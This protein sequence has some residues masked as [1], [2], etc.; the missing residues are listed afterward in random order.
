MINSWDIMT[1]ICLIMP[2]CKAKNGI[3]KNKE[4]FVIE[5]FSW[6]EPQNNHLVQLSDHF[7]A[8]PKLKHIIKSKCILNIDRPGAL[9]ELFHDTQTKVVITREILLIEEAIILTKQLYQSLAVTFCKIE[10]PLM[11]IA[12]ILLQLI[13]V[14][15]H[16]QTTDI[17]HQL[18][19]NYPCY[20]KV[21]IP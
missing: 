4:T 13:C 15:P 10:V 17:Y 19:F 3:C 11:I 14:L 8:E 20:Q 9:I 18:N 21:V 12:S 16:P 6:T 1:E 5:C 2:L 7:R